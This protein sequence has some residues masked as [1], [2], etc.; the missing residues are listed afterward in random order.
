[1]I[2]QQPITDAQID[3]VFNAMPDGPAGFLKSWGYRQFAR[4]LLALRAMPAWEPE[5]LAMTP[6]QEELAMKFC[7]EIAGPKGKPGRLPD[8]VRLLEMAEELYQAER[9]AAVKLPQSGELVDVV[10]PSS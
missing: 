9:Q 3:E 1:M 5:F 7:M 4:N 8:P 10:Q 2:D 6:G